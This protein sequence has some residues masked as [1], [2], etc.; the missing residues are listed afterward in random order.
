MKTSTGA[1]RGGPYGS[2]TGF[3]PGPNVPATPV[4]SALSVGRSPVVLER[5]VRLGPGGAWNI[6]PVEPVPVGE[7][8]RV[9]VSP[10][11]GTAFFRLRLPNER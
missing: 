8:L 7:D 5:S 10:G 11:A 2:E 9:V 4:P 6:V 1:A 3:W